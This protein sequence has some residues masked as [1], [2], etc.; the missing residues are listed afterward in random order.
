MNKEKNKNFS[1]CHAVSIGGEYMCASVIHYAALF[2]HNVG[3]MIQ[4][5]KECLGAMLTHLLEFLPRSGC[6]GSPLLPICQSAE[7]IGPTALYSAKSVAS[8]LP[9]M[10]GFTMMMAY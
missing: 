5:A 4:F 2:L 9:M 3:A 6:S 8:S 1:S 7:W 10:V